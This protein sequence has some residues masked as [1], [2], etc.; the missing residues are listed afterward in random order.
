MPI[1]RFAELAAVLQVGACV[2]LTGGLV[3]CQTYRALPSATLEQGS[4]QQYAKLRVMMR[5]GSRVEIVRAVIRRDSVIGFT[6]GK[7]HVRRLAFAHDQVV[8]VESLRRDV[9][10]RTQMP[11]QRGDG[12]IAESTTCPMRT[13]DVCVARPTPEPK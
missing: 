2:L 6:P 13:N 10:A 8:L 7:E 5:D 9:L 3:S 4:A 11:P 12:E 1:R